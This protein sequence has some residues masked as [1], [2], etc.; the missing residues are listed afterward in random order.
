MSSPDSQHAPELGFSAF[1][2]LGLWAFS[3]TPFK[4]DGAV[5]EAAL[6]AHV[7]HL[8]PFADC[9][10]ALGAIAEVDLLTDDEWQRCLA[11]V[12]ES[13]QAE[14]PLIVGVPTDAERATR[15][16]ARISDTPAAAILV[17]LGQGDPAR[18]VR[19][20]ADAGQRP[21]IPYL[22]RPEH[23]D[24]RALEAL[25]AI[26]AVVALKDGLRDPVG[27]RRIRA[28]AGGELP[29]AAA[30]E[31]VA[32][33]YWE[34]GANAVSPAS[35]AHDPA[36][37]RRWIDALADEGPDAAHR[38]LDAFGHPFSELRRSRP[39]IDVACVK[40]AFA[41]RGHGS[42]ITRGGSAQLTK[43]EEEAVERLLDSL[44]AAMAAAP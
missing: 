14:R 23:A 33:A 22:R 37:A 17:P 43:A 32:L 7:T 30:W 3:V 1:G 20:I 39:G 21:V 10:V 6:A 18:A 31:D 27:F 26:E 36:Y 44:D 24:A 12:T 25:L 13:A 11:V 38:L 19:A 35:A 16:A 15:L 29:M 42:A 8:T 9:V 4:H 5:D 41:L 2:R 34:A 28:Q 40:R